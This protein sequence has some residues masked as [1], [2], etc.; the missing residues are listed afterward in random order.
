[1][2]MLLP[3][4]LSRRDR[5]IFSQ[6]AP[7]LKELYPDKKRLDVV[8]LKFVQSTCWPSLRCCMF[9]NSREYIRARSFLRF[10]AALG[11]PDR[12]IRVRL[13]CEISSSFAT[14]LRKKLRLPEEIT[15]IFRRP[16][17]DSPA[18][19]SKWVGIDAVFPCAKV[20][21]AVKGFFELL[22]SAAT[23]RV[24]N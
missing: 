10:L 13:F 12:Q 7:T 1:M 18:A 15:V 14:D 24:A 5:V 17:N 19:A 11:I 21:R 8:A 23:R 9:R 6:F 20:F 4:N 16:P 22:R 3:P 2:E